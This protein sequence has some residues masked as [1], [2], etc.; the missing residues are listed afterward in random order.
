M[1]REW[2]VLAG[3]LV[4]LLSNTVLAGVEVHQF[5]NPAQEQQ[6]KDRKSVV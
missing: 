2:L 4:G 5:D 1:S 6:Y 3:L